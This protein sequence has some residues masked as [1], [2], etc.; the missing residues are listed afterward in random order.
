MYGCPTFTPDG[1]VDSAALPLRNTDTR[2]GV[3]PP[4]LS[5]WSMAEQVP[6]ARAGGGRMVQEANAWDNAQDMPTWTTTVG[7]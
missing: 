2:N 6:T 5:A 3:T 1:P 4:A 7:M